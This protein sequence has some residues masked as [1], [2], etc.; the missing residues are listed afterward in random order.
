MLR[1]MGLL[2]FIFSKFALADEMNGLEQCKAFAKF[3]VAKN[4][5]NMGKGNSLQENRQIEFQYNFFIGLGNEVA[6]KAE[7]LK[8]YD[9]NTFDS[10][11]N[12]LLYK[13]IAD[14][15]KKKLSI[16]Q[17]AKASYKCADDIGFKLKAKN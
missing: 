4:Y 11:S 3:Q 7:K 9:A 2:L 17:I 14:L 5:L 12:V 10:N 6:W 15:N 1:L 13:I 16:E 8:S